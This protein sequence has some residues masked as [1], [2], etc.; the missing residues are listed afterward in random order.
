MI[1]F[2]DATTRRLNAEL[3]VHVNREGLAGGI[4]PFVSGSSAYTNVMKTEGLRQALDKRSTT[5]LWAGSPAR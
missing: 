5:P 3:I 4:D 1:A 2:R